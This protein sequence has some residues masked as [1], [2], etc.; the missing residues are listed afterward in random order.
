MGSHR[1]SAV[2]T[3]RSALTCSSANRRRPHGQPVRAITRTPV[4]T[5]ACISQTPFPRDRSAD[6]DCVPLCSAAA[7]TPDRVVP[8]C[9][10]H[11]RAYDT[12]RLELLPHLEPRSRA[13]VAH[14][15]LHPRPRRRV[16]AAR[17]TVGGV[18]TSGEHRTHDA[19]RKR[20][21]G[22]R[23]QAPGRRGAAAPVRR[24]EK[25]P[26]ERPSARRRSEVLGNDRS[27]DTKYQVR[28]GSSRYE[29]RAGCYGRG[30]SDR[31]PRRRARIRS[32]RQQGKEF[33]RM[34]AP[35]RQG[36]VT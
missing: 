21:A 24:K 27:P 22:Q 8:L 7:T 19:G 13:E 9:W 18:S 15:V 34:R 17:S 26:R 14:A 3:Q 35:A 2:S 20:G 11:H 28:R 33:G 36:S 10:M 5:A 30:T 29:R 6:P 31:L 25:R 32:S 16:S 23:D 12:G 1:L 4:T